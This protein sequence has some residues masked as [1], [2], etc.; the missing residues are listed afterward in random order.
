MFA[1]GAKSLPVGR[2]VGKASLFEH[3]WQAGWVRM[4]IDAQ[5]L[6]DKSSVGRLSSNMF[7]ISVIV[8]EHDAVVS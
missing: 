1:S 3:F 4:E 7:Q 8:F 6:L 2:K 5:I